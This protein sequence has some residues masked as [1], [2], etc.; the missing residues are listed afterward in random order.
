MKTKQIYFV[1]TSTGFYGK[2]INLEDAYKYSKANSK[3]EI[4][5]GIIILNENCNDDILNNILQCYCINSFGAISECL[6]LND[7]DKEYINL[8]VIDIFYIN[9]KALKLKY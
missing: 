7:K 9:Q 5:I 8:Y 3:T 2:G 4:L 6:D 1:I